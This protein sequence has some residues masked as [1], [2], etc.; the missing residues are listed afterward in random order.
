[1]KF[2]KFH[3]L[4]LMALGLILFAGQAFIWFSGEGKTPPPSGAPAAPSAAE[5]PGIPPVF[6]IVGGLALAAGS[7]IL[8]VSPKKSL[9]QE[10]ND[11]R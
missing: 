1:M 2:G 6:G 5:K 9:K 8:I 11:K 10:V 4:T 3:G 7:I